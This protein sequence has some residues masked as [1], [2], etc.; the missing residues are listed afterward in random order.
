MLALAQNRLKRWPCVTANRSTQR[1]DSLRMQPP[2]HFMR[3][4]AHGTTAAARHLHEALCLRPYNWRSSQS[5]GPPLRRERNNPTQYGPS[6][7]SCV[8]AQL[9]AASIHWVWSPDSGPSWAQVSTR[10]CTCVV[11]MRSVADARAGLTG[12]LHGC[13][14]PTQIATRGTHARIDLESVFATSQCAH[15]RIW[16]RLPDAYGSCGLL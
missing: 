1:S 8:A 16:P 3:M 4:Q 15:R 9:R 11:Y 14:E 12:L 6:A 7:G 5:C 2:T 13:H 10:M